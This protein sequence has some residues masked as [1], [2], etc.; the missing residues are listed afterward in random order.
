MTGPYFAGQQSSSCGHYY[1]D[2]LRLR[3]EKRA[4]GTLVR[5][6]DCR[7]CGRKEVPLDP[8]TLDAALVRELN[9]TG[10]ARGVREE[11]IADV[12]KQALERF[13]RREDR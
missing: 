10:W 7:Y 2:V 4:D 12:R 8:G 13:L 5:I 11:E 6:I 3:D 1:P 9:T